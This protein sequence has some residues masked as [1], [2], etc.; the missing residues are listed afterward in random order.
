M[1]HPLAGHWFTSAAIGL[2]PL[3]CHSLR[4]HACSSICHKLLATGPETQTSPMLMPQQ[5][6]MEPHDFCIG[7]QTCKKPW[8][9]V[10]IPLSWRP[11]EPLHPKQLLSWPI[12][13]SWLQLFF[14]QNAS[15]TT[16]RQPTT[17]YLKHLKG[18]ASTQISRNT[19]DL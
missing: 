16:G 11:L 19:D 1:P 12:Q 4:L 6:L 14:P 8:A 3:W 15:L 18:T 2:S 17:C 13:S 7:C 5:F 9:C 10:P